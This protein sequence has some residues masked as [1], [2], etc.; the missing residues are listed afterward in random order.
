[1]TAR[2][3]ASRIGIGSD[4]RVPRLACAAALSALGAVAALTGPTAAQP[5]LD[6]KRPFAEAFIEFLK[7]VPG[8]F[9]DE[10]PRVRASLDAMDVALRRWDGLVEEYRDGILRQMQQQPEA[11]GRLRLAL[12]A[13]LLE[14]GLTD[15]AIVELTEAARLD[16]ERGGVRTYLGLAYEQAGRSSDAAAAYRSA[17]PLDRQDPTAAYLFV[18]HAP[19]DVD[20]EELG[21]A[22]ETMAASERRFPVLARSGGEHFVR[23]ALLAP[24]RGADPF[25]LPAAYVSAVRLFREANYAGAVAAMRTA[26]S[27]DPLNGPGGGP[28]AAAAAIGA[29]R[30]GEIPAAV[31]ALEAAVGGGEGSPALHRA[32]GTAYWLDDRLDASMAQLQTAVRL[33]PRD[34]RSWLLL[35]EVAL[36][37]KQPDAAERILREA[38]AAIPSSGQAHWRL[39]RVLERQQRGAEARSELEAALVPG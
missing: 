9:G 12:G 8:T 17:W 7:A 13:V 29:L 19:A 18:F 22:I 3:A 21:R 26:W 15:Q 16:P 11:A 28:P 1:M 25:F 38:I 30:R 37:A 27:S 34:E 6:A 32:L 35:A 10:S 33:D 14:R 39:A 2:P 24:T 4:V 20:P 36:E 23:P 31:A 5:I